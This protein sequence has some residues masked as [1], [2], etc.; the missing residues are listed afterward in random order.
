MRIKD[1]EI[2]QLNTKSSIYLAIEI[3][4]KTALL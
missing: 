1:E 2:F 3:E 4:L